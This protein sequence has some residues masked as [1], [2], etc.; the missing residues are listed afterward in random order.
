[1]CNVR[2][3]HESR[4]S[5]TNRRWGSRTVVGGVKDTKTRE[6]KREREMRERERGER[7]RERERGPSECTGSSSTSREVGR[8]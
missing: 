5:D 8:Q 3:S 1:M 4:M 6:R 7:E 2:P